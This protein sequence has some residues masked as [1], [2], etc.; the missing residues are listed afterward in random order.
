MTPVLRYFKNSYRKKN[1]HR[2]S[3]WTGI[4]PSSSWIYKNDP[5]Q[6]FIYAEFLILCCC[7]NDP[8]LF[9]C[10]FVCLVF[11]VHGSLVCPE[12]LNCLLFFRKNPSGPTN[13]LVFQHFCLFEPFPKMTVWFWDPSFHTDDN[14]GAHVQL[15]QKMKSLTDAPEGKKNMH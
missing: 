2:Y 12:Q 9:F 15:L 1:K 5:V 14:W 3:V 8:Q 10:L 6:K 7:L 11:F 4:P 13:Y